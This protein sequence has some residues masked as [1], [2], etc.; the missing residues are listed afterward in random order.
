PIGWG[1]T[2][3]IDAR[4]AH[5]Q[6]AVHEIM[7][8]LNISPSAAPSLPVSPLTKAS[9]FEPR[10]PYKG[11]RAFTSEDARDF[12]GRDRLVDELT[13]ALE[14]SLIAEKKS[15]QSERLLAVVGPSGSGKSSVVMAGF[16]SH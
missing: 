8:A 12:F 2:Q 16:L 13:Q 3:Y 6:R 11:L 14:A 1:G 7:L 4:D 9:D 15:N 5:Y 10:N